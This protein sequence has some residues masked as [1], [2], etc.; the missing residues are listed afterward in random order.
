[1]NNKLYIT[2]TLP[3][4]NAQPHIGYAWEVV[5]ADAW[6]RFQRLSGHEVFFNIGTDEHGAKIYERAK[7]LGID[8]QAYCDQQVEKFKELKNILNLS[9][10][11]FI[12]TTDEH[13]IQAAQKFWKQADANGYIYKKNY[14]TK[15]CI[16]CEM[17]KTDSELIDDCCPL[18]P[19]RK[20]QI[21]EEENYFFKFSAF[22]KELLDLYEINPEFVVPK[23]RFNEIKKF[24]EM[25]LMDFSIS[26]IKEKMPWGVPVPGDENHVIYVWFDA[27]VNYISA[28]GWPDD[29]EKFNSW[30]PGIQ[31]AG[32]DNI[33][34][35][36]AMWQAMLLSN[37]LP[38][39]KQIFINS[40]IT[41]NGQKM[42]KSLGNVISPYEMV[43]KFDVDGTRYLLL[44]LN[45]FGDD[46]DINWGW[47]V[48]K[49]NA[50]LANGLGNLT[51]RVIKLAKNFKFKISDFRSSPNE[52]ISNFLKNLEINKAL[53][54]I[55]DIV[56][57]DNK[58][59]EDN[60]PWEL[61][62]NDE[63]KFKEVMEKLIS[64]LHLISQFLAPFLPETSEKIKKALETK[65]VEP[66]FQRI[67]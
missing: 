49:Y 65:Q 59:I 38:P 41:S 51:S 2:T 28:I 12:R 36:S 55:W 60:K 47:M 1:M 54:Y 67:K 58:Y 66:L 4:V 40:F 34:Q 53:E 3:Y 48:E 43:E 42:S 52:K 62:K 14:K 57:E 50:D 37:K 8:T 46:V 56:K 25:G 9:F 31:V 15:Y 39:S 16:G 33:R 24:V 10:D 44:I 18:H 61:S 11:N 45:S 64:D 63:N 6:A 20:I 17:E 32:K 13:H 27:L 26:R 35:Q 29:L 23:H 30:W 19:D 7:E 22:Q 5:R 21:V